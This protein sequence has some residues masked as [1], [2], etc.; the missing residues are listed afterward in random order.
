M[1]NCFFFIRRTDAHSSRLTHILQSQVENMQESKLKPILKMRKGERENIN[2]ISHTACLDYGESA[3]FPARSDPPGR[4]PR[5]QP[6]AAPLRTN[7]L[8]KE[9]SSTPALPSSLVPS[10][11]HQPKSR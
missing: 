10:E 2:F 11:F 7:E 9:R 5:S 6:D 4:K 3:V 8:N 1:K